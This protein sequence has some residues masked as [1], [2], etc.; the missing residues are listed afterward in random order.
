MVRKIC[1]PLGIQAGQ[2]GIMEYGNERMLDY[3]LLKSVHLFS[4]V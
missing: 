1:A 2:T 3:I 4:N